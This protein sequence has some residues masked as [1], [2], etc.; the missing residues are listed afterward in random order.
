TPT[1]PLTDFDHNGKTIRLGIDDVYSTTSVLV[2]N[3]ILVTSYSGGASSG[4]NIV[5]S[6]SNLSVGDEVLILSHAGTY[7]MSTTQNGNNR[8]SVAVAASDGT[9]STVP[10]DAQILTLTEGT[11]SGTFGLYT[12]DGYLH[13]QTGSNNYL[14]TQETNDDRGS[15]A[16]TITATG[17][18]SVISQGSGIERNTMRFN[19]TNNPPIFSCYS[20]GQADIAIY[21]TAPTMYNYNYLLDVLD[22]DYCAM[23]IEGLNLIKTRYEAMTSSEIAHFNIEVITGQDSNEYTGLEAYS[24]AMLRRARFLAESAKE[25]EPLSNNLSESSAII[26]IVTISLVGVS[27][28]GVYLFSRKK[29]L[30]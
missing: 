13:A 2:V 11:I 23:D 8:G 25:A 28:I 29:E 21:K 16:I 19:S 5:L 9:L 27:L 10:E 6:E 17:V 4:A 15:W 26:A 18:A 22:G 3:F 30:I 12:G 14:R 24:E 20:S 7:A 1:T